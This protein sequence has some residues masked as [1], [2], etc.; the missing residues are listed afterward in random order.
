MLAQCYSHAAEQLCDIGMPID[1]P[2]GA[3]DY[4]D[5]KRAQTDAFIYTKLLMT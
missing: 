4:K 3:L 2:H 5:E 1:M